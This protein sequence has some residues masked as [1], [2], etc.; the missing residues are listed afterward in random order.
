MFEDKAND[1]R[2]L[3]WSSNLIS[4]RLHS[5]LF[6]LSHGDK[7]DMTSTIFLHEAGLRR[8]PDES[9]CCSVLAT[10]TSLKVAGNEIS[11]A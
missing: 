3:V 1:C 4:H 8:L 2:S 9:R 6:I 10:R 11:V 5:K 7:E